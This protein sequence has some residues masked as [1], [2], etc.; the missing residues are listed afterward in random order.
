VSR[1]AADGDRLR[2]HPNPQRSVRCLLELLRTQTDCGIR[3]RLAV[4]NSRSAVASSMP[5]SGLGSGTPVG[6]YVK[7][8]DRPAVPP[9]LRGKP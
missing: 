2:C 4:G 3:L 9:A 8:A 7:D 6:V 1:R 5:Y